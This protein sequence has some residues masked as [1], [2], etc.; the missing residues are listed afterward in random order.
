MS[1]SASSAAK[2]R[3]SESCDRAGRA[4]RR[5]IARDTPAS[6]INR[7]PHLNAVGQLLLR[8][9]AF[10]VQRCN[11]RLLPVRV[12]FE[13]HACM[14]AAG[15]SFL[16]TV[17]QCLS[18][19]NRRSVLGC[20]MLGLLSLALAMNCQV[21]GKALKAMTAGILRRVVLRRAMDTPE[22]L[23]VTAQKLYAR[24]KYSRMYTCMTTFPN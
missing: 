19:S 15:C 7:S 8:S 10:I 14:H 20:G 23:F 24:G 5:R 9:F 17:P 13:P 22:G 2:K 12:R 21:Q 6:D 11:S 3:P 1:S 4:L 18:Q 16:P